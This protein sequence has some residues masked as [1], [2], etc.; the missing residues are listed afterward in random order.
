MSASGTSRTVFIRDATGLVRSFRWYDALIL[1][2][3]V[4]GPTYFGVASQIGFVAPGEPGASFTISAVLGFL[5]MIPLGIT[6]YLFAISMPRSGGD[7]V[8]I[9]RSLNPIIGFLSG[10]V[11]FLS[12]VFLL[13]SGVTGWSEVVVPVFLVSLGYT[14]HIPGWITSGTSIASSLNDIFILAVLCIVLGVLITAFG[15]RVYSRV[16]IVLAGIIF[17]GTLIFL[18]VVAT[19]SNSAF[20]SAFNSFTSANAISATYNSVISSASTA[21]WAFQPVTTALTLLSIPFGVLLFNGFN[22]SVYVSGE[23]KNIKS[24]MLWGV[25]LALVICGIIDIIGL[26]FGVNMIGYKFNQAAFFLESNGKWIFGVSPWLALFV[27]MV[28]G[29]SAVAAFVQLGWLL[30]YIWWAAALLLAISRYVFAFSFD[31]VIPTM[32]ADINQRFH[33]PLKATLLSVV[34]GA[35]MVAFD[36]YY[37]TYIEGVLNT[38]FMWSIVWVIVGISAIAFAIRKKEL[39]STLPGGRWLIATFGA[40]SAVV[41]SV[42]FYFAATTPAI[43]PTTPGA[44]EVLLAIFFSGVIIYIASYFYYKSKNINLS[45]VLKEIPPE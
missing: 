19:T 12:F 14:L 30:F 17:L 25:L 13:A 35:A 4:T 26:Y 39:A 15:P 6:Y 41:M 28:I 18:G 43:G 22:Y 42:T 20:A 11:M 33:F 24:S 10:W 23:M 37:A 7:Y 3:A 1:S 31:R 8:W 40:I 36:T 2:L 27:P 34:I 9:G 32:F 16:M 5:F 21:G 44:Y 38:T 45:L 29:N